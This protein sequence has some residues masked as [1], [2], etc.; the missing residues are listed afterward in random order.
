MNPLKLPWVATSGSQAQQKPAATGARPY[1]GKRI[2]TSNSAKLVQHIDI[3]CRGISSRSGVMHVEYVPGQALKRYLSQLN[4]KHTAIYAAVYDTQ[5]P[6]RG[7]LRLTYVPEA[8]SHILICPPSYG[9]ATALQKTSVDVYQL[10][11]KMKE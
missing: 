11:S 9:L 5:R 4:L 10:M 7:R 6:A 2:E 3:E 8:D 1:L